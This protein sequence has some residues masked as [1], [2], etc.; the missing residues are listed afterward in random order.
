MSLRDFELLP[1]D[2]VLHFEV[3]FVLEVFGKSQVIF[4]N[5]ESILVF[6]QNIEVSFLKL[7][8]NLQMASSLHLFSGKSL[9][10]HFWKAVVNVLAN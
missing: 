7:L 10:L 9:P 5:A 6:A 2:W 8:W 4:V 3:D 1:V